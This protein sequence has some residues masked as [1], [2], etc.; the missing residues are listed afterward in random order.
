MHNAIEPPASEQRIHRARVGYIS[1]DHLEAVTH[2]MMSDVCALNGRVVKVVKVI[3]DGYARV[4]WPAHKVVNQM[5]PY[6][7]RSA[8]YENAC[9]KNSVAD[10]HD[11][12]QE[13]P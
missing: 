9:H 6:E 13:P 2:G 4:F 8:C 3:Y 11:L 12:K 10:S 7:A 1:F 5:T